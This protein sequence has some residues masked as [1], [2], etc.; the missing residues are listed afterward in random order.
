VRSSMKWDS[1]LLHKRLWC[2]RLRYLKWREDLLKSIRKGKSLRFWHSLKR[3]GAPC[4]CYWRNA[5]RKIRRS[6]S[7]NKSW[8]RPLASLQVQVSKCTLC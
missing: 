1:M 2:R 8:P 6:N 7:Q 3:I 4:F 5:M